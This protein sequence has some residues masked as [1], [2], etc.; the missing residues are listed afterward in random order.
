MAGDDEGGRDGGDALAATGEAEP[1]GGR[2]GDRHRR[3]GGGGQRRLAPRR[4]AGRS[5]GRLP[6]TWTATLP[7]SKPAS[8]TRRAASASRRHRRWR[9][10]T[11]ARRCR[12]CCPGRR[13]PAAENSA[14]QQ[15]CAATSPSE[16]PARPRGSSGKC[17]PARCIGTP[18]ASAC[19]SV[20]MPVR[21]EASPGDHA[22]TDPS[23]AGAHPVWVRGRTWRC[24]RRP[25][26]PARA[27]RGRRPASPACR[28]SQVVTSLLNGRA[29][30][31][32][33]VAEVVIAKTPGPVAE[34]LI[35][36]VGRN[37]KPILVAGVTV[38]I[39]AARCASPACSPRG[40]ACSGT[41]S[42]GRWPRSR[43]S[44]R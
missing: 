22:V 40:A 3:A 28:G 15:A 19:T 20:P 12:S 25:P 21:G 27:R 13:G 33:V 39:V 32:Q 1:V 31:V 23:G 43:W 35:H 18:S 10:P 38:A 36:V 24:D 17:S 41:W 37:D 44:P 4:G 14:S 6:I 26:S 9:R 42:S 7:I 11:R 29:T 30:P 5:S 16:W 2:R 8:R 34:S